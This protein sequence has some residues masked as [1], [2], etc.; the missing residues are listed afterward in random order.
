[1]KRSLAP[2]LALACA[3]VLVGACTLTTS[4]DGYRSGGLP[5]GTSSG[6]EGGSTLVGPDGSTSGE[7]GLR[8][9]GGADGGP[10]GEG[11]A[12]PDKPVALCEEFDSDEKNGWEVV[13]EGAATVRTERSP[14]GEPGLR[15]VV[16]KTEP[17]ATAPIAYWQKKFQKTVSKLSFDVDLIYDNHVVNA[18]EYHIVFVI[19]LDHGATYNL[20]YV[21]IPDEKNGWAIQD[22]PSSGLIDYRVVDVPEKVRHHV[23][24]D[25]EAGGRARFVVDGMTQ[26]DNVSP[27]FLKAGL[28]S[29]SVGVTLSTV[30][31]TPIDVGYAHLVFTGE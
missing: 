9:E 5:D 21:T 7:A 4:F 8:P 24:F 6:G 19:G 13:V 28:P 14:E 17:G 2:M 1:M 30:P 31:T 20:L 23:H 3:I 18:G 26:Q 15:A 11:G 10:F 29:I 16:Q 25:A 12:C 22:F 27:A